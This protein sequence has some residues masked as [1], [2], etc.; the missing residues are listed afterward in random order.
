MCPFF[1]ASCQFLEVSRGG[2]TPPCASWVCHWAVASCSKAPACKRVSKFRSL[3][4]F[5]IV[6]IQNFGTPSALER[7]G[8]RLLGEVCSKACAC[9]RVSKFLRPDH[10]NFDCHGPT[11]SLLQSLRVHQY[12]RFPSTM[13]HRS[14]MSA[15]FWNGAALHRS[16]GHRDVDYMERCVHSFLVGF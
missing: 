11:P 1:L 2:L 7:E 6:A 8:R 3:F 10:C 4:F 9:R 16:S 5:F 15:F 12:V 14:K 13:R